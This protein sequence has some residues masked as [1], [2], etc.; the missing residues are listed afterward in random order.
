MWCCIV[1]SVLTRD[2]CAQ[3]TMVTEMSWLF[4]VL[5]LLMGV[6]RAVFVFPLSFLHN[7]W[8]REKL[9]FRDTIVIW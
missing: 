2:A 3:N 6:G 9:T 4:V 7:W 5:L 1:L 8:S